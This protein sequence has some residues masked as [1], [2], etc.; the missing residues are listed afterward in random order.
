MLVFYLFYS[1]YCKIK[2]VQKNTHK[3]YSLENYYKTN[4]LKSPLMLRN[5]I[6]LAVMI[7]FM[8]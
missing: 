2:Q 7:N 5:R 1:F 6:L 3:M 8:C 4:S